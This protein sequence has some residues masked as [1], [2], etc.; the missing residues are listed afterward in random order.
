MTAEL[1]V[2]LRGARMQTID[3]FWDAVA[4]PC[5]LP[6]WFGRTIEAWTDTIRARGISDLIDR[7]DTVVIHVDGATGLFAR[8]D[9]EVRDLRSSFAGR[10]SR[11]VVHR[12]EA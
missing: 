8:R 1:V 7:H 12:S 11:L 6:S 3:D 9:R 4:G 2:D 10:R 5:G